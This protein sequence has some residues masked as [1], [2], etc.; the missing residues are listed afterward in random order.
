MLLCMHCSCTPFA[1]S[2]M[3]LFMH[4]FVH[5]SVHI[6]AWPSTHVVLHSLMRIFRLSFHAC[7]H[8]F[9]RVHVDVDTP[10]CTSTW[11]MSAACICLRGHARWRCI[12]CVTCVCPC[13]QHSGSTTTL[14]TAM[15]LVARGIILTYF[16]RT[17]LYYIT[18][19]CQQL[20]Y[21][22]TRTCTCRV[23]D[24]AVAQ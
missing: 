2:A 8:V 9:F 16:G 11:V 18:C 24:N 4:S 15:P 5:I 1:H 10:K 21:S 7:V 22:T 13:V 12:M 14:C 19:T 6:F 3:H 20:Y 23:A 17:R